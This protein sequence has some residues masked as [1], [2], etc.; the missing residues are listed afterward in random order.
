MYMLFLVSNDFTF[1]RVCVHCERER[2]IKMA[3]HEDN[4]FECANNRQQLGGGG[5]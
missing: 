5:C 1:Y 3:T 2:L 4:A